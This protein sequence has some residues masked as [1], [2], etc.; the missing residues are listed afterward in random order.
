MYFLHNNDKSLGSIYNL[1]NLS[2]FNQQIRLLDKQITFK[3]DNNKTDIKVQQD[4][5]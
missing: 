2:F 5:K 3:H 4:W 1:I